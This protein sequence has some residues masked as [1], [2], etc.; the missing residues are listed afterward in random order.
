MVS[1]VE[2]G[3]TGVT[4]E[5]VFLHFFACQWYL[6]EISGCLP[7]QLIIPPHYPQHLKIA[8]PIFQKIPVILQSGRHF[9]SKPSHLQFFRLQQRQHLF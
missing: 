5:C 8:L 9:L 6:R 4:L 2:M 1:T 7:T 3:Q